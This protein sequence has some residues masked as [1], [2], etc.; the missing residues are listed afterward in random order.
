MYLVYKKSKNVKKK[1][2]TVECN[3]FTNGTAVIQK[4]G[5]QAFYNGVGLHA[6]RMPQK[7]TV[8]SS[9]DIIEQ[10]AFMILRVRV[11]H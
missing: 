1:K 3:V 8:H 10:G 2:K 7:E 11:L 4:H 5:D 9:W 6:M